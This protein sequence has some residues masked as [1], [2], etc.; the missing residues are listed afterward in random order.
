MP[1]PP[2]VIPLGLIYQGYTPDTTDE[3]ARAAHL[4]RYGKPPAELHRTPVLVLT[5]PILMPGHVA[6][7]T[8][9]GAFRLN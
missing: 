4:R 8:A 5:G 3:Q 1:K 9:P 6:L 2:V 7:T